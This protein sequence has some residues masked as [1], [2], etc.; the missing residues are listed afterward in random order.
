[1]CH[2]VEKVC[3]AVKCI[4]ALW[5]RP[6]AHDVIPSSYYVQTSRMSLHQRITDMLTVNGG[7][8][9]DVAE[10]VRRTTEANK[11]QTVQQQAAQQLPTHLALTGA[12]TNDTTVPLP[13]GLTAF[14]PCQ[15]FVRDRRVK[16]STV[17]VHD[18]S[19]TVTVG[20]NISGDGDGGRPYII[21]ECESA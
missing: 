16:A 3:R 18:A 10:L 6:R 17:G 13:G 1:M 2:A 4:R 11:S 9:Y 21:I 15:Y 8:T 14:G 19:S 12:A 7:A 20:S 5:R